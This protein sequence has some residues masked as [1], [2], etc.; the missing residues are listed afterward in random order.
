MK[1][2]FPSEIAVATNNGVLEYELKY[3][4]KVKN[5]VVRGKIDEE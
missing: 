1:T 4:G 5:K 3:A 2:F